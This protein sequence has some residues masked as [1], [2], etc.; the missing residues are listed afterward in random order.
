M[1][2]TAFTAIHEDLGARMVD[3][4]GFKMPI[5]YTGIKDE[6]TNVREKLG[7]RKSVV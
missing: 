6:H 3:F 4:A 2:T 1:K 7:D 5:E